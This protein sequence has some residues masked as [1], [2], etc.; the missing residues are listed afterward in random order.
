MRRLTLTCLLSTAVLAACGGSNDTDTPP[1]TPSSS[2][3]SSSESSSSESSSSSVPSIDLPVTLESDQAIIFYQR[4][5]AD[6]QGWGLHLWNNET[7]GALDDA[8]IGAITWDAPFAATGFDDSYGAY[9]LLELNA[10]ATESGCVN[11]IVHKGDEKALGD[12]DALFDLS[13]G[14]VALTQHG[15]AN[16]DYPL[17]PS[18]E[19]PL[20]F[21][22]T[23]TQAAIF[24]KRSDANY[25]GWGLHLWNGGDCTALADNSINGVTWDSPKQPDGIDTERGAFF[26][27]DLNQ[28]GGCFNFIVH[29][30]DDKALGDADGVMDLTQGN[31]AFTQHGSSAITY[32]GDAGPTQATLSGYA[33]HWVDHNTLLWDIPDNTAEVQLLRDPT[34]AIALTE[35]TL[36]GGASVTLTRST[37][38][39]ASAAKFPHLASWSAWQIPTS[40]LDIDLTLAGELVAAAFDAEGQLVKATSVQIA[41]ALDAYYATD[42]ELGARITAG[43]TQFAVWAPTAQSVSVQTF[44]TTDTNNPS[45]ELALTRNA[46][47]V[48]SGEV[49]RDMHGEYYR[50][51]ASVYHYLT[52]QVEAITTT[53]PYALSLAQNGELSQ[54]VDLNRADTQPSNWASHQAPTL[55]A[56]E[57]SIIYELHIRDFSA[58]DAS[59]GVNHRG[60]YLAFTDSQSTPVKHLAELQQAGLNTIHLLPTFDI[61]TVNEDPAARVDITDTVAD[62][63]ALKPDASVCGNADNSKTLE[64]VLAEFD[65]ATPD[66][67]ALVGELRDIDSFNWGYDPFHYTAPEGS[68]A[69]SLDDFAPIREFRAM[70]QALH[71]MDLRVVMDVVYNHTNSSGL[72]DKSV[73][74]K[75]VPGYYHRRNELSG[76]VETSS[77]CDNTASEHDMM[78]KLMIDSLVVWA[79]D[80]KIDG[81]RFDLMGHHMRRNILAARDA[82]KTVDPDTYFYGE[83]WN[84][85]EVM[86]NRRGVNAIQVNMAGTGVGTFNDRIRDAVRGGGPFDSGDGIRRNQGYGTGLFHYPNNLNS[87]SASEQESLTDLADRLRVNLAGSLTGYPLTDRHGNLTTGG[88][89]PYF[90]LK[91]G[92]TEDPQESINYISK[93]DNQTLWDNLQYKAPQSMTA[94]E[95]TR[96]QNFSLS[97]PMLAQGIPFIHMGVE[98]L[99]SKS[100]QRDSYDSGDWFNRVDFTGHTNNWN[101]GLPREDKDGSNW[102]LIE[103]IISDPSAAPAPADISQARALFKEWLAIRTSSPLFRLRTAADV[104]QVISFHNTG[105]EQTAGVIVMSLDDAIGLDD[106]HRALVV[107]FN[108]QARSVTIENPLAGDFMLH[109]VQQQ[110]VDTTTQQTMA[111]GTNLVVPALTTSVFVQLD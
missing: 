5:D 40:D 18:N 29:R 69:T 41:G 43:K 63:C 35:G 97:V 98:L 78:E 96:M 84:F 44:A 61:A 45:A 86:S 106:S 39:D 103:S 95:R 38:S 10:P 37:I 6:Y 59:T 92:Y 67:Q 56:P 47:G 31:I 81:F 16:I 27:L 102:P 85:G 32:A 107:V 14:A 19:N 57:D 79:R 54:V 64:A 82:V 17:D 80:Y 73:L 28:P 24:Y 21:N 75:L 36:T 71:D 9:Y 42:A 7:C 72:W 93:H 89:L 8:A 30:G 13:R 15:A 33:A 110:S 3:S 4:D 68:Y 105:P 46:Q 53:D 26:I 70:V 74:D 1:V 90:D 83:G 52:D 104:E 23:D 66:A 58:L 87:G 50:Y 109:P 91:A 108:P 101:V 100:M 55:S 48:W 20:P 60:K 76:A 51:Q 77:C 49:N 62:L 12:A 65:P 99:R 11:F 94:A 111:D 34:G 2:S 22:L 25:E 88:E